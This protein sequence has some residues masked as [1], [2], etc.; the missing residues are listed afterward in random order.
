VNSFSVIYLIPNGNGETRRLT[1]WLTLVEAVAAAKE[2]I[3]VGIPAHELRI[4]DR[5]YNM[6]SVDR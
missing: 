2:Y 3:D 6:Q 1:R 4:V 5:N